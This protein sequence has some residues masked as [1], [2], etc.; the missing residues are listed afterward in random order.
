MDK[1]ASYVVPSG[2]VATVT[3]D[4]LPTEGYTDLL[5][6]ASAKSNKS[7][8]NSVD[9][10]IG[11]F[12]ESATGYSGREVYGNGSTVAAGNITQ[13]FAGYTTDTASPSQTFSSSELYIQNYL[14][15]NAK[16]SSLRAVTE[17]DAT[18][19]Y[20]IMAHNQWTGTDP[21]SS[22][23]LDLSV[24][25]LFVEGSS[26]YLFGITAGSDGITAVS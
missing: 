6:V 15:G 20:Q 3:F 21:I 25:T 2:G 10:I 7:P 8:G 13:L 5:L 23:L 14:S 17:D 11:Q 9:V 19:A 22:I 18:N 1:L 16:T 26:F 4:N 24:G 12:N